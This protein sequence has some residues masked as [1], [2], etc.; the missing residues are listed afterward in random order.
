MTI[1]VLELVGALGKS[2]AFQHYSVFLNFFAI[3][4][5]PSGK[6]K[7]HARKMGKVVSNKKQHT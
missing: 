3:E 7:A 1:V 4:D 5:N 2:G 6:K